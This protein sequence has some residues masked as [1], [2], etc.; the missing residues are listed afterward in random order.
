MRV[1]LAGLLFS[2]PDL[3]LLDEPSNHLDLEA[4]IW[5]ESFLKTYRSSII[6]VSHE[7]DLLN[8]VVDHILHLERGKLALYPGNY[9][10]FERQRRERQAQVAATRAKQEAQARQ[11]SGLCRSLALQGAY[12]A[13][14]AEPP[15]GARPHG[16]DRRRGGGCI[17]RVRL[18]EPEG[19]A[20]AFDRA[21]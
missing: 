20:A 8:N 9:D 14:G 13:P 12:G 6:V 2:E 1:A 15:E 5:L 19:V 21:R 16:A 3:M 4:T 7:R 18:P 17:T 11:A 10:A